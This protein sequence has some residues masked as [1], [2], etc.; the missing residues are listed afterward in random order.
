MAID[1]SIEKIITKQ[2]I[3]KKAKIINSARKLFIKKGY[4]ATS[5]REI[6]KEADVN[7]ALVNYYFNSKEALFDLIYDEIFTGLV[8]NIS[9]NMPEKNSSIENISLLIDTYV[10]QLIKTPEIASFI[11]QEISKNPY[12]L[13]IRYNNNKIVQNFFS[14]F[15]ECLN[16]DMEKGNIRKVQDPIM[17]VF[18]IISMCA[19]PFISKSIVQEITGDNDQK[20]VQKMIERKEEIKIIFQSYLTKID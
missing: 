20:F 17:L 12:R 7:L 1:K 16:D 8:K 9:I 4:E 11:F 2:K 13:T 6:A 18:N 3:D 15:F 10:N 19:F 5:T 14:S